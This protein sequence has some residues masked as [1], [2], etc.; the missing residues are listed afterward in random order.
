MSLKIFLANNIDFF[1]KKFVIFKI[2]M[3]KSLEKVDT[4]VTNI[5]LGTELAPSNI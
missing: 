4:N 1:L 2:K 3:H 5:V